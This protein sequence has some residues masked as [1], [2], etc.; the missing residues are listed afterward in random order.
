MSV[1]KRKGASVDGRRLEKIVTHLVMQFLQRLVKDL[2]GHELGHHGL[3]HAL[4][5]FLRLAPLS[6]SASR[7]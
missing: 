4:Q 5:L 1:K 7:V 6:A 3:E 2:L